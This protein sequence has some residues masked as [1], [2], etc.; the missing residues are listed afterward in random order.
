MLLYG[1]KSEKSAGKSMFGGFGKIG[2]KV[3]IKGIAG[4]IVD[5]V[6]S[7]MP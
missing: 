4:K 6:K 5:L 2:D 7:F 1:G 3:Q